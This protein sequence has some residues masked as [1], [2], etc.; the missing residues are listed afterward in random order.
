[1]GA[2]LP[3]QIRRQLTTANGVRRKLR[4]GDRL[5]GAVARRARTERNCAPMGAAILLWVDGNSLLLKE[6]L[7]LGKKNKFTFPRAMLSGEHC[8]FPY[9]C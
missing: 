1:M 5:R 3:V 6:I 2:L 8:L 7:F 4:K 9:R